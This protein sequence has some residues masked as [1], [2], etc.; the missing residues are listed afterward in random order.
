MM[1]LFDAKFDEVVFAQGSIL[2]FQYG[3]PRYSVALLN[4][5]G[6][7]INSATL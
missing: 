2:I 5:A 6:L 1:N 7:E 4:P 3:F